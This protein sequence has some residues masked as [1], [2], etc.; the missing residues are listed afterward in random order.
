MRRGHSI[1]ASISSTFMGAEFGEAG[2][3]RDYQD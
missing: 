1:E 2:I 3:C